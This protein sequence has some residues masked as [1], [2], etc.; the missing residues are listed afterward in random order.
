MSGIQKRSFLWIRARRG[1]L[2]HIKARRTSRASLAQLRRTDQ[3]RVFVW[4]AD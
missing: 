3:S 4:E 2:L 1:H